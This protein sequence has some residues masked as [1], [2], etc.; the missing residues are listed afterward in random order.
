VPRNPLHCKGL[1][2]FALDQVQRLDAISGL[3]LGRPRQDNSPTPTS[4]LRIRDTLR[5]RVA[6][7]MLRQLHRPT[8]EGLHYPV[9]GEHSDWVS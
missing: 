3:Y 1:L 7:R 6:L 4:P 2:P 9:A 5:C 8:S